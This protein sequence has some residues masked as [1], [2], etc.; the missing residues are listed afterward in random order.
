MWALFKA[1]LVG[2]AVTTFIILL[3]LIIPLLTGFALFTV[4]VGIAYLIFS[5]KKE[6]GPT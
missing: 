4:V 5:D 1:I 6:K 3:P 2:L